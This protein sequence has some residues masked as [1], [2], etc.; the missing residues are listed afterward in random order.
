[1]IVYNLETG[2]TLI[3]FHNNK[4]NI[5]NKVIVIT[6]YESFDNCNNFPYISKH[7]STG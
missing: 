5:A 6:H 3:F 2:T 7:T 4:Y 1:M